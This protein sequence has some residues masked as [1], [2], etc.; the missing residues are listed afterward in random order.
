METDRDRAVADQ[1]HYDDAPTDMQEILADRE[2][3]WEGFLQFM[4]WGIVATVILLIG[5]LLFVA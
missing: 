3:G 5:L 4:T 2:R 1:Q